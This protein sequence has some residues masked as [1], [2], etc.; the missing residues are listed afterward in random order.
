MSTACGPR[1]ATRLLQ[2]FDFLQFFDFF[3]RHDVTS[4]AKHEQRTRE[5]E[6]VLRRADERT[7]RLGVATI[8]DDGWMARC[9]KQMSNFPR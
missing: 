2:I 3:W 1:N 7:Q 5:I 8:D 9:A 6:Q 4:C